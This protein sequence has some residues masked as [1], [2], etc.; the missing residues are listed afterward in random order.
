MKGGFEFDLGSMVGSDWWKRKAEK[1]V[2]R[3]GD[4]GIL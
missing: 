4:P 1:S 2:Q 3:Y